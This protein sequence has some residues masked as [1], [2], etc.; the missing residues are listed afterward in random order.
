MCFAH[1]EPLFPRKP[2]NT[3]LG[4]KQC[5]EPAFKIAAVDSH[6]LV[7]A[8]NIGV[9]NAK[10]ILEVNMAGGRKFVGCYPC[11]NWRCYAKA[12]Y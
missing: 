5:E 7:S 6:Q 12:R 1:L 8:M 10:I 11:L 4:I 9:L 3:V 2:V